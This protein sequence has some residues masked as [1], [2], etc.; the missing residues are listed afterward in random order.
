MSSLGYRA[1]F[2]LQI[3]GCCAGGAE[4]VFN[5][6]LCHFNVLI[7]FVVPISYEIFVW[8]TEKREELIWL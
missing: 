4:Y 1:L 8:K 7:V 3:F 2:F 5:K 6:F